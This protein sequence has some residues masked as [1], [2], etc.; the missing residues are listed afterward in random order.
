MH[1]LTSDIIGARAL[2]ASRRLH[3]PTY[4]ATRFLLE[5]VAGKKESIWI[6]EVVT[7]KYLLKERPEYYLA[8]KFKKADDNKNCIYREFVIPTPVIPP[9]NSGAQK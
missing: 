1:K 7:R 6:D 2:N 9:K 5:T 4:V 8:R 3:L